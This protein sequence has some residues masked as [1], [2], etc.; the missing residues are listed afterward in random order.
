M[1]YR[2]IADS[3]CDI[4]QASG[5]KLDVTIVPLTICI[6][7]KEFRG[8]HS[9][10][11]ENMLNVMNA[12]QIA[13]KT[14]CPSPGDFM[15]AYEGEEESL[16]VVTLSSKISGTFSS[17]AIAREMFLEKK[18][19]FIHIFDSLSAS[20]G[21]TLVSMKIHKLISQGL[22]ELEVV[23]GVNRYIQEMKTL[24]LIDSLDNLIKAGRI[25]KLVGKVA[26]VLHV[27]PIMGG[28]D[29][30]IKMFEKNRGYNRAFKR[31]VEIIGEIGDNLEEKTLGIAHCN[32]LK[33]AEKF[34][35]EVLK[36]YNFKNIIIVSMNG[37]SSVYAN[38]GG[39]V[40]AF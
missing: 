24:F 37:L 18:K 32:C 8:D 36:K 13:P 31:L 23:K 39:L 16:F 1:K 5:E 9:L 33:R 30:V 35:D 15:E 19:K 4:N 10:D 40:I 38:E 29:G 3:G 22:S 14:A 6:G 25:N 21:E 27:K 7:D 2:I 28:Q 34:R 11:V 12:S 26:S 17:A 20:V